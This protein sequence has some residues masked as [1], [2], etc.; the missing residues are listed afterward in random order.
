MQIAFTA[1]L[2]SWFYWRTYIYPFYVIY[3]SS[4]ESM[5]VVSALS[6]L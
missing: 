3:S 4:V 1:N 6:A 2:I 5:V